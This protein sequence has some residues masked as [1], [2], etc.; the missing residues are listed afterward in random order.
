[1]AVGQ[2]LALPSTYIGIMPN[3]RSPNVFLLILS[4]D[5]ESLLFFNTCTRTS[6]SPVFGIAG[7]GL[8]PTA[9]PDQG[10]V[11]GTGQRVTTGQSR[12][13]LEPQ[14]RIPGHPPHRRSLI[15]EQHG[16]MRLRHR[17]SP[18][19]VLL[20]PSLAIAAA[21]ADRHL[22]KDSVA[23]LDGAAS[24]RRLGTKDAPVDGI[25]GKPH[26]G[27]FVEL[28]KSSES[29]KELPRLK[30]R[31]ADP[32]IVDGKRIPESHDGVMDDKNR[33]EP[34]KGTTGTEGGVSEKDKDRKLKEKQTGGKVENK[35][36]TPKEAP[37][38]P[39]SDQE[40]KVKVGNAGKSTEKTSEDVLGLEVGTPTHHWHA[41]RAAADNDAET[42]PSSRQNPRRAPSPSGVRGEYR[43]S[44]CL[45]GS[46]AGEECGCRG[47]R[48]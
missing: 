5:T 36:Q 15:L 11:I 39:H 1:M 7:P 4:L 24:G 23:V 6:I 3:A 16:T 43:P 41:L 48:Q 13:S 26:A 19:L 21:V 45:E 30:D 28:D 33:P 44:R 37:P 9:V 46:E 25:D 20:I 47:R 34:K 31:P 18:L 17:K 32:L 14:P 22:D 40:Q 35:P 10:P 2:P 42:S 12:S 29:T 8:F 27:P 38:L